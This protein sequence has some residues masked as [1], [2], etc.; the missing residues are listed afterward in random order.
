M[1]GIVG[2]INTRSS[3]LVNLGS[4]SDGEVYTGTGAGLPVGFEAAGGGITNGTVIATTSGD[5]K[6][7]TGLTGATVI[8]IA[9]QS[10]S[11][12]GVNSGV[13]QLGD[14]GGIEATGY[15][16]T[17]AITVNGGTISTSGVS[18][19][20]IIRNIIAAQSSSGSFTLSLI[21]GSS[22]LWAYH[23][24]GT[25]PPNGCAYGGGKKALSGPL[26]QLQYST[27]GSDSFDSGSVNISWF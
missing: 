22:N 19:G 21:D 24:G 11:Q 17:S 2:G 3:G 9:W 14:S 23:G 15:T 25:A 27:D 1:S 26:T 8:I 4:A 7:F 20:F 16:T 5:N 18:T 13:V 6:V 12:D 10:V